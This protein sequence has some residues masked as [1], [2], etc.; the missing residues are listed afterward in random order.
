MRPR[1]GDII[2]R[3]MTGG[4]SMQLSRE[5]ARAID[6]RAVDEFAM[7]SL[8][9]MEN[10]GR[11]CAELL[12]RLNPERG[13]VAILCGPGNNGG[14]G[15]VIARQLH[16][17]GWPVVLVPMH[18]PESLPPDAAVNERIAR[19]MQLPFAARLPAEFGWC[20]DALFGTGL[21]RALESPFAE[22][23]EALNAAGRPVL[24]IDVPSGLD[25]DTGEPLGPCVRASHTATFVAA[26]RGFANPAAA[27]FTGAVHIIG[28]GAPRELIDRVALE[29]E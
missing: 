6:R 5:Q 14:D 9:L 1:C 21:T 13:L 17:H 23:I 2:I 3:R 25:C 11:G 16:N 15:Y 18:G 19:C 7:P 20:V 26:K 12:L 24:A 4:G 29:T 27:T 8:L 28:I 10:A 22:A